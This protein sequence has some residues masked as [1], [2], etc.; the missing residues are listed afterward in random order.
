MSL[1]FDRS[2]ML[3]C[4]RA[5]FYERG[6][7]EVDCP[8]LLRFPP[9]DSG[10]EVMSVSIGEEEVRYLHTSPEYAMKKLLSKGVGDIFYLGHVFRKGELGRRHH[11]EFTMIEWYRVGM[12]YG[13]FIEETSSL[14]Q[15]F[16]GPLPIERLSYRDAFMQ[17]AGFDPFAAVDF[18][19]AAHRLGIEPPTKSQEWDRDAWLDLI[20]SHAVEPHLGRGSLTALLDYPASQ[21]ALA[22]TMVCKGHL[23]AER[24]EFYHEGVELSNGYHELADGA[25]L[26]SRFEK[27]NKNRE[28]LGKEAYPEFL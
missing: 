14:I 6:F 27:E 4:V 25:E 21:A 10:I 12:D 8:S 9:L 18:P 7:L 15:L 20:L 3:R 24:F 28:S 5:F 13:A 16:L 11:P 26:R 23:V 1:V 17:F 2:E 19:A 22:R